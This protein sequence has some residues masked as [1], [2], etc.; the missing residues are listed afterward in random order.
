M[1]NSSA[2]TRP[3][4]MEDQPLVH[5]PGTFDLMWQCT[6]LVGMASRPTSGRCL[7]PES[8]LACKTL[9]LAGQAGK[10]PIY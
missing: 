7:R 1:F 8:I 4:A 9:A 3:A 6:A 2:R 5:V 10:G